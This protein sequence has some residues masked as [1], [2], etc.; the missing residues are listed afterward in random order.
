MTDGISAFL[1]KLGERATKDLR[2][3]VDVRDADSF[4]DNDDVHTGRIW[5]RIRDVVAVVADLKNSTALNFKKHPKTSTKLYEAVTRNCVDIVSE[6]S[7]AANFVDIQ[8]DGLFA[9]FHGERAYQRALC[10]G[11]TLK[12]F[13]EKQLAPAI[14]SWE[15]KGNQFPDTGLKVGMHAG[16]LAVKHV[17]VW[18]P[19]RQW[20]EPVWAGRPVNWAFKCAQR[21]DA[22]QLICT[23]SVF[24]KFENN[25]Y[26]THSCGC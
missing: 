15:Q 3:D 21:A 12:T 7:F 18:T 19:S 14:E 26:V 10:A 6:A 24:G 2:A 20:R 17:G 11:I 23:Q 5:L 16:V 1:D 25:N 4:P 9:L 8:G 13:S 22:H